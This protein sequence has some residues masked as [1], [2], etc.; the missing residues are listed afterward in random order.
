MS[1]FGIH[2]KASQQVGTWTGATIGTPVFPPTLVSATVT[3]TT[4]S[5]A[6]TGPTA[7][8]TPTN[9]QY[10]LSTDGGTTYGSFTSLSPASTTSPLTLSALSTSQ[11]YYIK[12][13]SYVTSTGQFSD[14]VETNFNTLPS[15]PTSLSATAT[16]TTSISVSFSQT[17]GTNAITNYEY[18]VSST[19]ASAGFGSWTALSP[20]DAVSPVV[21]GSLTAG[22]Q[23]WIKLR[24]L[25]SVATSAESSA[26]NT[27]T[28]PEAP[29]SI[30]VSTTTVSTQV[31]TFSQT[32]T[33]TN[34]KYALSTNAGASYGT[35]TAL[36]PVD[37]TSPITITGLTAATSYY[38]K[39]KAVNASGDSAES[40][41]ISFTT[42]NP[43]VVASGGT[44]TDITVGGVAYKLHTF[45][46]TANFVVTTG[47][48][49]DYM[50]VGGGATSNSGGTGGGAGQVRD[51]TAAVTATSYSMQVGGASSVSS[52]FS[53]T[54]ATGTAG[55]TSGNGFVA[56]SGYGSTYSNYLQGGGA[57]ATANGGNAN[58]NTVPGVGGAGRDI[59]TW[60]GQSAAT[61]YKG[62]G[63][64]GAGSRNGDWGN[65]A[66]S[67]SAGGVGG[68]GYGGNAGNQSAG[69]ANSGG[70]GGASG[71][72]QG[73][74]YDTG[75]GASGGSGVVYVRYPA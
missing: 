39:I 71:S 19:S 61:T 57:G 54:A 26:T 62:G 65:P 8:V 5:L 43:P 72:T 70:G 58:S 56:G 75:S 28:L 40:S 38:V 60:L 42:I 37:A 73:V 67:T 74:P 47:G 51:G 14:A 66:I 16:S 24:A 64:G 49:I 34:Y 48:N 1:R 22:T 59:S 31:L 15:A 29:T 52:G 18:A 3:D 10:A 21:I 7:G 6:Y 32:G 63:G 55:G 25:T 50:L 27:Y 35:F 13:R 53:I 30:T 12:V 4:L 68:G 2:F 46:S 11:T 36:S 33:V 9:Y 45:T 69:A 44:I 17:T 41:A 23:Y 20:V